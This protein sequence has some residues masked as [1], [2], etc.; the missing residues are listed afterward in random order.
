MEG[1]EGAKRD[2][3]RALKVLREM[4]YV[5]G[6]LE[7]GLPKEMASEIGLSGSDSYGCEYYGKLENERLPKLYRCYC[8]SG[9][10]GNAYLADCQG[11]ASLIVDTS[12]IIESTCLWWRAI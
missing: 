11:K 1:S 2:G 8:R 10:V 9:Y 7:W 4:E 5:P 3:V 6:V 12:H